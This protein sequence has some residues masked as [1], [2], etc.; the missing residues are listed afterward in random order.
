MSEN[1]RGKGAYQKAIKGR[2]EMMR[3]TK[4][5]ITTRAD[6]KNFLLKYG[7]WMFKY[8]PESK[9]WEASD[10]W[11]EEIVMNHFADFEEITEERAKKIIMDDGVF[12][13]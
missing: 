7:D 1:G 3:K 11:Y 10:Y 5:Y 4:Y 12:Q 6:R 9:T 13:I 8:V 2:G